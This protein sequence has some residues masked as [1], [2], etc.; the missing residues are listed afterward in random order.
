M[1]GHLK[2]LSQREAQPRVWMTSGR[3]VL[4][5]SYRMTWSS[6][7]MLC[8]WKFFEKSFSA[9]LSRNRTWEGGRTEEEDLEPRRGFQV[10]VDLR[11]LG[12]MCSLSKRE[13]ERERERR[14]IEHNHD[15]L[16]IERKERVCMHE[17]CISM[18]CAKKIASWVE[19]QS[20]PI[21]TQFPI[22]KHTSK[23]MKHCENANGMQC[24]ITYHQ[25]NNT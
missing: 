19:T 4:E 18:W 21:S 12:A 16:Q 10:R 9:F 5:K 2:G 14:K 6:E 22:I 17:I 15:R 8:C 23:C 3:E 25:L 20:K 1:T 11:C 24:M 7:W 13:R